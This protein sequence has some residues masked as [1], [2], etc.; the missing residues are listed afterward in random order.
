GLLADGDKTV[1][2]SVTA[3]DAAGNSVTASATKV[4]GIEILM[5]SSTS[6]IGGTMGLR[7]EYYGYNDGGNGNGNSFNHQTGDSTLGNLDSLADVTSIINLRQGS[8]IVGTTNAA[9]A[10]AADA[11]FVVTKINYGV[12]TAISDDLGRNPTL[13]AGNSVS[14]GNLRTFLSADAGS[15]ST[16]SSFGRTTDAM[17][18]MVGSAYF[19]A[20]NYDFQ[21][22]ID[23]GFSIRIDGVAI[24]QSDMIQ[25]PTTYNSVLAVPISGGIHTVE[26][27][28]WDQ[29]GQAAFQM[30]FRP[31]GTGAFQMFGLD[32]IALFQ[33]GS[34]PTLTDFQDI[35]ENPSANGQYLIRTGQ[36]ETGTVGNDRISGS[37][38]RDS[39]DGGA[40]SDSLIGGG[41][42][43]T[44]KWVLTDRGTPGQAPIDTVADF[45]TVAYSAGGDRLDLRDL[46][47]SE[48][49]ASGTGNLGNYLHFER[50]GSDTVVHVSSNGGFSGGYVVGNEDQRIILSGVDLTVAGADQ[51][52]IQDLLNK[53]K[54]IVD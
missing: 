39:I 16:T 29:G 8:S 42:A 12:T 2:A 26:I 49:H 23:D 7:G 5:S 10:S 46:L 15:L 9:S 50:V 25:S 48:N 20:G 47:V 32:D 18:R 13:A 54:L 27:L 33:P 24:F 51:A 37:A 30:Q 41:G 35:I 45:N 11:S 21:V 31:S 1:E 43:D 44:F 53:G 6:A 14:S 34:A 38:G 4:F 52:I 22:L 36:A 19:A 17:T 28:Y 40:G 3:T